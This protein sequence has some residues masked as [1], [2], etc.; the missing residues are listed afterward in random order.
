ME[1]TTQSSWIETD[2]DFIENTY[3]SNGLDG[4]KVTAVHE[5]FHAVQLAY[6]L[7]FSDIW[8]FELAS[9]WFEDVGYDEVNDYVQYI[10]TYYRNA[11]R[12]LF[13][14]DGYTA[15]IFGKFLEENYDIGIM[16][17]IWNF[18]VDNSAVESIDKALMLD[19]EKTDGIKA[20]FGKFALWTWYSG[21]RTIEGIFF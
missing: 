16:N 4:M 13:L 15:A 7:R 21:S 10:D 1:D 17:S 5:Y 14:S 18:I 2:N 3:F 9:T 20:A 11:H 19:V 8:F 6:N 12:S